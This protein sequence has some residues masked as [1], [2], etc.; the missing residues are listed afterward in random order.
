MIRNLRPCDDA[1][2]I[3]EIY[4]HYILHSDATFET[5]PLSV[6]QMGERLAAFA[7]HYPCL[8]DCEG[9]ELRGYCYAHLWKERAAYAHTWE[10]T[11]YIAP[12][13]VGKGIGQRLMERLIEECRQAGCH[14]LVSCLTAGNQASEALH[15][16]LGFARVSH[17]PQVGRKFDRWLDVVDYELML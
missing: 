5:E 13:H 2:A 6:G 15:A 12:A 9:D 16:K 4:N 3:T 11:V 1:G 10:A 14:A 8:V 7:P 17:F